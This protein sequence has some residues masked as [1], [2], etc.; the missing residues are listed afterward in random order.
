[1]VIIN[2]QARLLLL[3]I[4]RSEVPWLAKVVGG[5]AI[6][7]IFSPV[8]LIPSFIPLIGQMDDLLVLFLGTRVARKL[9]PVPVL[10]ECEVLAERASSAQIE[11]WERMLHRLRQSRPRQCESPSKAV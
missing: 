8:Q 9:T 3:L 10:N 7:Y 6:G 4:R 1:L 5:C 11:R 2:K